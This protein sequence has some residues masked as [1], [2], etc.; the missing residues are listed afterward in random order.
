M[1][2][3]VSKDLTGG[4]DFILNGNCLDNVFDPVSFLRNTTK[5]LKV[6]GRLLMIEACGPNPLGR[7]DNVVKPYYSDHFVYLGSGF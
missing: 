2:Y 3:P 7:R 1:N 4:Y 6:G 5:M